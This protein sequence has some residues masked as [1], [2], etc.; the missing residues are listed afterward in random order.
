MFK[1]LLNLSMLVFTRAKN[2]TT[3]DQY[4]PQPA[5][6]PIRFTDQYI[7]A[8]VKIPTRFTDQYIETK[9]LPRL[10]LLDMSRYF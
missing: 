10:R 6:I 1:L 3:N 2:I 8:P 9:P 7:D 5:K 4:K